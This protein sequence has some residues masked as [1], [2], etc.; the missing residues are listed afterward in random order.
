M[1]SRTSRE[2]MECER[3]NSTQF[4]VYLQSERDFNI[5]V[6][7]DQVQTVGGNNTLTVKRSLSERAGDIT[8]TADSRMTIKCGDCTIT[9]SPSG[10]TIAG[11]I[12]TISPSTAR[13]PSEIE[14]ME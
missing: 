13:N 11:A 7:N 1:S 5:L 4:E 14:V 3:N 6:K 8:L 2:N 10:I 12:V 9:L